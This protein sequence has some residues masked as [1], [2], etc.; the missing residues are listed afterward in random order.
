MWKKYLDIIYFGQKMSYVN[1]SNVKT[2]RWKYDTVWIMLQGTFAS[3]R[4]IMF[5]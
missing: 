5:Q 2:F 3:A 1:I 4:H